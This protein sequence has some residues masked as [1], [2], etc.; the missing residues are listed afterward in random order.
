MNKK[1]PPPL[2]LFISHAKEDGV[3][4]AKKLSDYMQSQSPVKT[5]F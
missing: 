4:V 3:V 5:F 1:S 2:K